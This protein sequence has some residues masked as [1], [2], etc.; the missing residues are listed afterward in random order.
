MSKIERED[1]ST[2]SNKNMKESEQEL[3]NI[4]LSGPLK[5]VIMYNTNATFFELPEEGYW[6]IDT[7][8]E[9]VFPSG[10]ISAAFDIELESFVIKSTTVKNIYKQDN[11]Y[12]IETENTPELKKFIG[13]TIDEVTFKSLDFDF[14]LDY[15]M[16]TEKQNWFVELNLTFENKTQIQIALIDYKLEQNFPPNDFVYEV[17]RELLIATKN[18]IEISENNISETDEE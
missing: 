11:L 3:K 10:T 6:I 4:L 7:G 1:I 14:V 8:I 9:L 16:K 15:T 17:C 12:P 2:T 13:L 18:K 5:D